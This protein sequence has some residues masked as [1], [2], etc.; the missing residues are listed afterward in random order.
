MGKERKS[1]QMKKQSEY[2]KDHFTFSKSPHA[3]PAQWKRKKTHANRKYRRKSD[4]LLAQAKP[5][6]SAIDAELIVGEL[7]ECQFKKS[8]TR[9]RLHKSSTVTVGE[10]VEIKLQKRKETIGRRVN[11]HRKFDLIVAKSVNTLTSLKHEDLLSFLRRANKFLQGGDP[12]EWVRISQSNDEMDRALWFLEGLKRGGARLHNAL[13]RNQKLC[14]I[15]QNWQEEADR[16]LTKEERPALRK[17]EQ[18]ITV[19]NKLNALRRASTR[20]QG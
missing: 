5:E 3:F 2:H 20:V 6:I 16:L 11:S 17:A 19:K 7:T 1:P 4:E 13:K 15:F 10:K 8:I 9:D 14:V 12:I 18:K